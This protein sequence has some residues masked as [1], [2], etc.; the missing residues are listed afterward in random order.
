MK[1]ESTHSCVVKEGGREGGRRNKTKYHFFLLMYVDVRGCRM[2][3]GREGGRTRWVG[4]WVGGYFKCVTTQTVSTE[5]AKGNDSRRR[6][7]EGGK[8]GEEMSSGP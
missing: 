6:R 3:G 4:G 7:R 2:H 1:I 5:K 8:E